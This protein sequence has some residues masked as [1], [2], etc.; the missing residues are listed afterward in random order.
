MDK[1]TRQRIETLH[2]Q[3]REEA[4]QIIDEIDAALTGNARVRVTSAYRSNLE[5]QKLYDQGRKTKGPIVTNAAG[6][7]SWH[8]YGM[9]L[10]IV[11]LIRNAKTG[12]W[13]SISY[14]TK[15]D[16]DGDHVAEWEEITRIFLA[17]GWEYLKDKSGRRYDFPH[18]Q[19]R[20][21]YTIGQL[22]NKTQL[23]GSFPPL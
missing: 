14:N 17:H 12:K 4:R 22:I 18:F 9:A 10:D 16:Y 11:L 3:L 1:I 6:G 19:N 2:P 20:K 15:E 21:G 8:N 5:Q 7:K 13:D 23:E